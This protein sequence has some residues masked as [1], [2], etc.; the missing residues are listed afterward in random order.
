MVRKLTELQRMVG[1]NIR[2]DREKDD[3]YATPEKATKALL[4]VEEFQGGIWECCCGEGAISKVLIDSGYTVKSTDLIDRGYGKS[5]FDFLKSNNTASNIVTNPPYK[6][7]LE[8]ISKAV[9]LADQ[10]V[11]MILPLR[12]LE[13]KARG[14]FYKQTP[15]ARVWVF[16]S[17]VSMIKEGKEVSA[18]LMAFAWFIWEK[19][20]TGE[21]K[22]G[23]V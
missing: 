23:W 12:Y 1:D 18:G 8:F 21:T 13:G 9:E 10:K 6:N 16:S 15:P 19:D 11:A 17:R 7:G 2:N 22:L 14:Q 3:F 20:A 5:G 4:S